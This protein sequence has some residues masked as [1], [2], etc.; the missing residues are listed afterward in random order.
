MQIS[1]SAR[2][3]PQPAHVATHANGQCKSLQFVAKQ[4]ANMTTLVFGIPLFGLFCGSRCRTCRP[5]VPVVRSRDSCS[6]GMT[7][8]FVDRSAYSERDTGCLADGTPRARAGNAAIYASAAAAAAS[9]ASKPSKISVDGCLADGTAFNRAGNAINHPESTVFPVVT[10]RSKAGVPD[11]GC[12]A[13][14]TPIELAGNRSLKF[15]HPA[16]TS[17]VADVHELARTAGE[18]E[19]EEEDEAHNMRDGQTEL[20]DR[21]DEKMLDAGDSTLSELHNPSS[22]QGRSSSQ[23]RNGSVRDAATSEKTSDVPKATER[24]Q[25]SIARSA[26]LGTIAPNITI[27]DEIFEPSPRQVSATKEFSS[28]VTSGATSVSTPPGGSTVLVDVKNR[29]PMQQ[30]HT[31]PVRHQNPA[32]SKISSD[33]EDD[34]SEQ[35][36]A[37]T[38]FVA[39]VL[40]INGS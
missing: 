31:Q 5:Q 2:R 30:K 12:L 39:S 29:E 27:P 15:F 26:S 40:F 18:A 36:L 10:S 28:G 35:L 9:V 24:G 16:K 14:G 37:V 34:I 25:S 8:A 38:A 13:D 22:L 32:G 33:E 17:L 1:L 21:P 7:K 11:A 20:V 19:E 3:F 6:Q 4:H 23:P